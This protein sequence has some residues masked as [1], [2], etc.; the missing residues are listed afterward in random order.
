M[1]ASAR[2]KL[3]GTI[4]AV[5]HGPVSTEVVLD[6]AGGDKLVA[7]VT[8]ASAERLGLKTGGKA[9][10]LVKAPSVMLITD[11]PSYRFSARNQFS[12]T[13]TAVTKGAVNSDVA[14]GLTGGT[15]IH[16]MVTN[17]AI[18]ELQ[19]ASGKPATALIKAS[20]VII[21]VAL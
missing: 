8:T 12:G 21:G 16:A 11:A 2:N 18:D 15:V 20:Q 7:V 6:L 10:G 9:V 3:E 13:I 14:V 19:L 17:E 1:K 4:A 5:N